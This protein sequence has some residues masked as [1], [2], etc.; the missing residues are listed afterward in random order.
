MPGRARTGSTWVIVELDE[1]DTAGDVYDLGSQQR[2]GHV[3]DLAA[4][5][6]DDAEH[7]GSSNL[8]VRAWA[9]A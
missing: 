3:V 2:G 4:A 6:R 7:G 1:D 8:A 5:D 9:E